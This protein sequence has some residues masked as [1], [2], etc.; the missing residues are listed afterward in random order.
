MHPV[1]VKRNTALQAAHDTG[2]SQDSEI[3]GVIP[4]PREALPTWP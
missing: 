3:H 4:V 1:P 2:V